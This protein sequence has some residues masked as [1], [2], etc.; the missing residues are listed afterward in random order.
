M[1]AQHASFAR[2]RNLLVDAL[3]RTDDATLTAY[4]A[5]VE[6][7]DPGSVERG[8]GLVIESGPQYI[9]GTNSLLERILDRL[10]ASSPVPA[11]LETSAVRPFAEALDTVTGDYLIQSYEAINLDSQTAP[12]SLRALLDAEVVALG[13]SPSGGTTRTALRRPEG[14]GGGVCAAPGGPPGGPP[15]GPPGGNGELGDDLIAATQTAS[16]ALAQAQADRELQTL[17]VLLEVMQKQHDTC[18]SIVNNTRGRIAARAPSGSCSFGPPPPGGPPGGGGGA[19]TPPSAPADPNDKTANSQ[20]PCEMGTVTVDGVEIPRCVRYYVPRQLATEPLV[21]SVQFENLPQATANAEFV[22][23]TDE[24]DPSLDPSTL[25]V[26]GSSADSLLT[27]EVV[28]QT[29]TFRFVGIDLPPNV[30]EPE[31]QGFVTFSVQPRT[32]LADGTEI[33]NDAEIVFDF[34]PAIAT[35][36]VV[37]EIREMSDLAVTVLSPDFETTDQPVTVEVFVVHLQGDDAENVAVTI[38]VPTAPSSVAVPDGE[39]TGTTTLTCT[40]GMLTEN[41]YAT[42]T[43]E[44]PPSPIGDYAITA[45]ASSTTFDGFLPNNRESV[46]LP[47]VGVGTEDDLDRQLTLG[48][49]PNPTRGALTLRWTLPAPADVE[50]TVF[51]LLGREVARLETSENTPA[52]AYATTWAAEVASG[53][54]VVRLRAG[55]EVRTRRVAVLR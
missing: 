51:D 23:I 5:T 26:I 9:E 12:A 37:H 40:F 55:D 53:V 28:G 11:G 36:E 48:A 17:R 24:L 2:T 1:A 16:L 32:G 31:G 43:L 14:G 20:Y 22:T 34:N 3:R 52:G 35:P 44:L 33:R 47:I 18:R 46:G 15:N 42:V 13:G 39:C 27:A 30:S 6:A 25:T 4:L 49:G 7:S 41:E 50:L 21:Y 10:D 38:S 45:T 54:Y 29:A 8:V 19:C